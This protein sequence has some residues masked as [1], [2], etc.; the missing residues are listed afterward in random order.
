MEDK[1][2]QLNDELKQYRK[3][4]CQ[5]LTLK[6]LAKMLDK[7]IKFFDTHYIK[8]R[9]MQLVQD[10]IKDLNFK[11]DVIE[12]ARKAFLDVLIDG[13]NKQL[14]G[15]EQEKKKLKKQLKTNNKMEKE[16]VKKALRHIERLEQNLPE[17]KTEER[18]CECEPI[19]Q[20]I[21]KELIK[22]EFFMKTDKFFKKIMEYDNELLLTFSVMNDLEELFTQIYD[23][24]DES[25]LRA[26][27]KK[28][29]CS[30]HSIRMKQID[31]A[32]KE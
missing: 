27:E 25:Y 4:K 5:D 16:S 2:K 21:A 10:T 8:S 30:R 19:C 1:Q 14:S 29:G 20:F 26:N 9:S 13:M 17:D 24:V 3:E 28:W 12:K 32:L 23:S 11:N 15:W 18:E 31:N 6:V 22:P 7:D